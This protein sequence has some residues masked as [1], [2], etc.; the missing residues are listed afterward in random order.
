MRKSGYCVYILHGRDATGDPT[1]RVGTTTRPQRRPR[2]SYTR[3]RGCLGELEKIQMACQLDRSTALT[4]ETL[5][6]DAL[7]SV[8]SSGKCNL[9]PGRA[10]NGTHVNDP[11]CALQHLADASRIAEVDPDKLSGRLVE[12]DAVGGQHLVP[13]VYQAAHHQ[14]SEPPRRARYHDHYVHLP[15]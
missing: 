7:S 4:A 15:Q 11:F 6:I 2:E 14:P 3:Y 9:L 1:W 12:G 13:S 5:L 8:N 10:G